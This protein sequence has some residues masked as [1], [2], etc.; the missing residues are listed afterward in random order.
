MRTRLSIDDADA[1]ARSMKT[2][3]PAPTA[4]TE[5]V[6][7]AVIGM[8]FPELAPVRAIFLNEGCDSSAFVINSAWVFRFPKRAE[9]DQQ[10]LIE[11]RMLAA[12]EERSPLPIPAFRFHGRPSPEFPFHFV[13][14]ARIPGVPGIRLQSGQIPFHAI[15]V[16]LGRFLTWLHALPLDLPQALGVPRYPLELL[17]DEIGPEAL[18]NFEFV[19]SAA[20]DAPLDEWR[21]FL[22]ARPGTASMPREVSS[23]LHNDFAAEHILFD[24]VRGTVTG[25]VDWSDMAI[26]HPVADLAGVFHWGG[27][28]LM[29]AVLQSYAGP[30]DDDFIAWACYLAACRGAGDVAFGV[31]QNRREYVSAGLRALALCVPQPRQQSHSAGV[32]ASAAST[33]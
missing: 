29:N 20:P 2:I 31:L 26:G 10:L 5:R 25:I 27:E 19:A 32:K 17:L 7:A 3:A 22:I 16:T 18:D 6:A 12:L 21:A 24:H 28:N 23:L 13:G 33:R 8:Q 1:E 9:I 30:V 14:Y 11:T 15:A 4:L